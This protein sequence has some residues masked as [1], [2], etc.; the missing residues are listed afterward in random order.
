M[1]LRFYLNNWVFRFI[2][3]LGLENLAMWSLYYFKWRI[4]SKDEI[5]AL[6]YGKDIEEIGNDLFVCFLA[7]ALIVAK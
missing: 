4:A 3:D 1:P 5:L 7:I 2:F 6:K